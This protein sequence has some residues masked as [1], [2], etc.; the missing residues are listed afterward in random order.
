M[1]LE[2][3]LKSLMVLFIGSLLFV[4]IITIFPLVGSLTMDNFPILEIIKDNFKL[5]IPLFI[6][7]LLISPLLGWGSCK[8][9][10]RRF[11]SLFGI[12]IGGCWVA[13]VF[14]LFIWSD[15]TIDRKE[16]GSFMLISAWGLIAY[17]FIIVPILVP[18]I[19]IIEKWTR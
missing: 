3:S 12:C 2:N 1:I 4:I 6:A 8:F 10:K 5:L 16:F 18:A 13:I 17:S 19:I 9:K 7:S 15:F 11:F 14:T